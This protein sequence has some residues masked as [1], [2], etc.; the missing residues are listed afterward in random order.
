MGV[1]WKSFSHTPSAIS[2]PGT[3]CLKW[4]QANARANLWWRHEPFPGETSIALR[5]CAGKAGVGKRSWWCLGVIPSHRCCQFSMMSRILE[6]KSPLTERKTSSAKHLFTLHTAAHAD[7]GVA[8]PILHVKYR[9]QFLLGVG[10]G[11][12]SYWV[13]VT[14]SCHNWKRNDFRNSGAYFIY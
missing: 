9:A 2:R 12:M 8:I 10:W 3:H 1:C 5:P 4:Q 14:I 13:Y 7:H 11:G 6:K